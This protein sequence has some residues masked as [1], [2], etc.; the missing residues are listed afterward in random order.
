[1]GEYTVNSAS[2]RGL[3]LGSNKIMN[4]KAL[5]E[6]GAKVIQTE[7]SFSC[8]VFIDHLLQASVIIGLTSWAI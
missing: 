6:L 8:Q 7:A 1:M 2:L 3:W 4:V 5:N